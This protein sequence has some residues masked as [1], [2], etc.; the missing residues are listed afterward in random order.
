[1]YVISRTIDRVRI[2]AGLKFVLKNVKN[3]N[4]IGPQIAVKIPANEKTK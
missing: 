2:S 4:I 1:M 3:T